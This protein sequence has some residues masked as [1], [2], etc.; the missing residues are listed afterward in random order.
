MAKVSGV[1]FERTGATAFVPTEHAS[2]GWSTTEQLLTVRPP[3][4]G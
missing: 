2:G 1:F 3:T 4:S